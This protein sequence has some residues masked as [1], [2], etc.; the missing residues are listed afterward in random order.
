VLNFSCIGLFV[1][2]LKIHPIN[3]LEIPLFQYFPPAGPEIIRILSEKIEK[4]AKK[5]GIRAV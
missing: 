4:N 2:T 3:F 1:H 5:P